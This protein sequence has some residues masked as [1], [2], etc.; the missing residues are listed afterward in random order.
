MYMF[1]F[2]NDNKQ[3]AFVTIRLPLLSLLYLL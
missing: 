2:S 3:G 1:G